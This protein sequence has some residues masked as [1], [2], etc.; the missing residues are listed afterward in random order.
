MSKPLYFYYNLFGL[1]V[2]S[3]KEFAELIAIPFPD[4]VDVFIRF[5]KVELPADIAFLD[6]QIKQNV[7]RNY[8]FLQLKNYAVFEAIHTTHTTVKVDLKD[9]N[10]YGIVKS[11]LFGSIFTAVLQMNNRFALHASAVRTP[12]GVVLFCGRS[13]IGKSTI[14]TRLNAHGFDIVSDD[15]AVLFLNS[16]DERIYIEPSIQIARLWDDSI[17]KLDDDSF[18]EQPE[19]VTLKDNK[20]QFLI[21][22]ENRI[23]KPLIV[24]SIYIIREIKEEYELM[25]RPL[26]GN[27]KYNRLRAQVHRSHFVDKLEKRKEHWEYLSNITNRIPVTMLLRPVQTSHEKFTRFVI[28]KIEQEAL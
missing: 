25:V 21:K 2:A 7:E 9:A 15:K 6:D 10:M 16:E 3:A 28:N 19:S 18:L 17:E 20:F 23:V 12:R 11:W 5:E 24:V 27:L 22:E 1:K 14:A 13:G 26:S 8:Y 4:H